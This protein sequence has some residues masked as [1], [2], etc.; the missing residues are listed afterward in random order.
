MRHILMLAA[1]SFS[2]AAAPAFAQHDSASQ[3]ERDVI[4]V[5][6]LG[7]QSPFPTASC[8]VWAN[9]EGLGVGQAQLHGYHG[10]SMHINLHPMAAESSQHPTTFADGL[11]EL[12]GQFPEVPA[13][14]VATLEKNRSKIEAGCAED[15][16]EP[17]VVHKMT[18]ADHK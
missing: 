11:A 3:Y 6:T 17:F 16:A 8:L 13:W 2:L 7:R 4:S 12:K 1:A 9:A 5:V 10:V 18:R 14:I 15:H